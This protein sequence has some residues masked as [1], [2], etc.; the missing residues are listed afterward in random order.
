MRYQVMWDARKERRKAREQPGTYNMG[1][2]RT[3]AICMVVTLSVVFVRAAIIHLSPEKKDN[4]SNIAKKQYESKVNL[5]AYRG[6]IYDRRGNPLAISIQKES[7]FVNPKIFDP[8][9]T[10]LK[11]LSNILKISENKIASI[12]QKDRYFSWLKRKVSNKQFKEIE[13]LDIKGISSVKEPDRFYPHGHA[14]GQTLGHVNIDNKGVFGLEQSY[15][16]D[17]QGQGLNVT[18]S[19]DAKGRLIILEPQSALPE[20]TGNNI[21][22]TID[23]AIQ[24]ITET[25][26]IKGVKEAK[27]KAGF[28]IVSDP[29]TGQILA[30]SNYPSFNPNRDNLRHFSKTRNRAFY[31]KFEPGSI[32]K[33]FT[34]ALAINEGKTKR[35][36]THDCENGVYRAGGVVFRD[37][38]PDST[39]TTE[40]TLVRSSNICT[41]KIAKKLGRENLYNGF[42]KFG[43]GKN[44][45]N[46]FGLNIDGRMAHFDSWKEIRFANI[47]F[48]Q[49]LS[50]TGIEVI[51]AM[52]ALA[53]GGT[54]LAPY[55]VSE[56]KSSDGVS[57]FRYPETNGRR[58]IDST[59]STDV[60]RMLA[61]VVAHKRGSGSKAQLSKWTSG[62][63]TG[64]AEKYDPAIKGYHPNKRIASWVG[65]APVESPSL[66]VYVM[67]D[68]PGKKPYYGGLWA[69]PVFTEIMEGAL[70]YLNVAPDKV[71]TDIKVSKT[72]N[73]SK[74]RL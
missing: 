40:M 25:A 5:S 46:I 22:L 65:F 70:D 64:T 67:I 9:K 39:L 14:A 13:S 52:N 31:D 69:A 33:P 1:R 71:D 28:A 18:L 15:D 23:Q 21:H 32:M 26:L 11:K 51:A 74:R 44:P 19:R 38:H 20:K 66:V 27:A 43:F 58:V 55:M 62:G 30:I 41:Y 6:H 36:S 24:E 29:Y 72:S 60:R 35:F 56:I 8:S 53:N 12:A 16:K 42:R 57:I 34:V 63:K 17:L 10:Q 7:I 61:Q 48:G 54:L 45:E 4:L 68:E 50:V 73:G 59:V 3:I 2:H 37:D 47:A 49:G